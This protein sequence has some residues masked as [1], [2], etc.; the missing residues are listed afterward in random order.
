MG[1][2]FLPDA[3]GKE[4]SEPAI[5]TATDDDEVTPA[6]P[7]FPN[8]RLRR[9]HRKCWAAIWL[10]PFAQPARTLSSTPHREW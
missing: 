5:L 8:N 4:A 1:S 6:A 2:E 3:I 9:I 7:G 10:A